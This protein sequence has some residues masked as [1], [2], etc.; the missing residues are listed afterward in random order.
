MLAVKLICVGRMK[1]KFYLDAFAEY[2]FTL[3]F[4]H[5]FFIQDYVRIQSR[6][7]GAI[8]IRIL[9]PILIVLFVFQVLAVAVVLKK[10]LGRCSRSFI[11]A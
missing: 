1:E 2:S 4:L 10:A 8:S 5:Y 6:L 3:F 9:D 7:R 11:G